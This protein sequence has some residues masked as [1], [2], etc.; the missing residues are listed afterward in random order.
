MQELKF[1]RENAANVMSAI[2]PVRTVAGQILKSAE[3][4]RKNR[5]AD[6]SIGIGDVGVQNV[7]LHRLD[8]SGQAGVRHNPRIRRSS[9]KWEFTPHSHTFL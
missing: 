5:Q 3:R 8:S 6:D 2:Q 1:R 4:A 9:Q 7:V